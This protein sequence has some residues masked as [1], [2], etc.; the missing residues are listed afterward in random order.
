MDDG[1]R[2]EVGQHDQ[3][4]SSRHRVPCTRPHDRRVASS[5]P[6]RRGVGVP[7]AIQA[8][9]WSESQNRTCSSTLSL[10]GRSAY[11]RDMSRVQAAFAWLC[12]TFLLAGDVSR[13]ATVAVQVEVC[14]GG[15]LSHRAKGRRTPEIGT[16][17]RYA[18]PHLWPQARHLV[19][20]GRCLSRRMC[21]SSLEAGICVVQA[22]RQSPQNVVTVEMLIRLASR[23]RSSLSLSLV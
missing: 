17:T 8:Q 20:C 22:A 5:V 4:T 15:F 6:V 18:R 16:G 7:F 11:K 13:L 23:R 12:P 2:D 3:E 9:V 1:K 14:A 10:T 19:A 21:F